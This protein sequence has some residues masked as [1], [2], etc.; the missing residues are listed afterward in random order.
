M[1]LFFWCLVAPL[2]ALFGLAAVE[3]GFGGR[4]DLG[5]YGAIALVWLV[6]GAFVALFSAFARLW[7]GRDRWNR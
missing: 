3:M 6:G 1:K 2:L 7:R 4:E 5:P